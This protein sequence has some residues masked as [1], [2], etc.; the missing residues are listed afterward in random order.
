MATDAGKK[1]ELLG[2]KLRAFAISK[3]YG[4]Y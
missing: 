3:V 2:V 4:S 1:M